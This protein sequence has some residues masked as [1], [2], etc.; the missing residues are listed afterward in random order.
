MFLYK[1]PHMNKVLDVFIQ[2]KKKNGRKLSTK[3]KNFEENH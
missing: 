1:K 3:L 2:L